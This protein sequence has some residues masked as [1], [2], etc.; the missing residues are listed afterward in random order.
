MKKTYF[1]AALAMMA[2]QVNAQ[3]INLDTYI[4]AQLAT[5]DLNLGQTYRPL[6]Q[7]LRVSAFS[8]ILMWQAPLDWCHRPTVSRFKTAQRPVY[9]LISW[10]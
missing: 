4:G 6:A 5:E 3:S 10:E 2:A 9:R 8:V 7:T 1:L